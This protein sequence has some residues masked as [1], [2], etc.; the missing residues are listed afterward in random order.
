[1]FHKSRNDGE[2]PFAIRDVTRDVTRIAGYAA[3]VAIGVRISKKNV[4]GMGGDMGMD[5]TRVTTFAL[6]R[7]VAGVLKNVAKILID[8]SS[9]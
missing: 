9:V 3:C 4:N 7:F 1:M 5:A 8:E 6:G 2:I